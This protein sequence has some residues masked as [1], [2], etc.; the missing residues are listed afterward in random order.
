MVKEKIV[1]V[2]L[3]LFFCS[4]M[5]LLS[6][7]I[8]YQAHVDVV[9]AI[10]DENGDSQIDFDAVPTRRLYYATAAKEFLIR[11]IPIEKED[12]FRKLMNALTNNGGQVYYF[13]GEWYG[14]LLPRPYY[15]I[16]TFDDW[17]ELLQDLG[18]AR[19]IRIAPGIFLHDHN[20]MGTGD[21]ESWTDAVQIG[22][23]QANTVFPQSEFLWEDGPLGRYRK[24]GRL[25]LGRLGDSQVGGDVE[26]FSSLEGEEGI[27]SV[28]ERT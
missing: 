9:Y 4:C 18:D 1:C 19:I 23:Q 11:V 3:V 2:A 15:T 25:R 16:A 20:F 8:A 28:I 21:S 6:S 5:L 13:P 26:A 12:E 27:L 24:S 14:A 17:Q 10:R 7:E 22:M